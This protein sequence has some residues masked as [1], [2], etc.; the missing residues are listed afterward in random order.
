MEDREDT[1]SSE[2]DCSSARRQVTPTP[3]RRKTRK[4]QRQGIA[5]DSDS[6]SD[7]EM[8]HTREARR[9]RLDTQAAALD[10]AGCDGDV[11]DPSQE[12]RRL[13]SEV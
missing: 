4:L 13:L 7:V 8:E 6:D 1:D 11:Q 3:R 9:V 12:V 2:H 10:N 5:N